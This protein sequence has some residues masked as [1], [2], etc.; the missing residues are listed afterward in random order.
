M[1]N[2]ISSNQ[3]NKLPTIL[4]TKAGIK[5]SAGK[6]T[7][8]KMSRNF[9]QDFCLLLKAGSLTCKMFCFTALVHIHYHLPS[10]LKVSVNSGLSDS[11]FQAVIFPFP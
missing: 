1:R 7:G 9:L 2:Q 10:M 4:N 5:N 11:V 6:E 8:L 3:L